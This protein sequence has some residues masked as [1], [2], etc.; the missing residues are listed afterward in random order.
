MRDDDPDSH[1]L[2]TDS[3]RS[4]GSAQATPAPVASDR[5]RGEAKRLAILAAAE[6]V[7]LSDGFAANLDRIAQTAGVSKQTIYSH[8]GSKEGLF[9]AMG[10]WMKRPMADELDPARPPEEALAAFGRVT[11]GHVVSEKA[12]RLNRLLMSQAEQFPDLAVLHCELGP[13]RTVALAARYIEGLMRDG[14]LA[15]GDPMAAAEDFVALLIGNLRH[16]LL[17]GAAERP[18][19]AEIEARAAR[20]A[21]L[22]LRTHGP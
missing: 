5:R 17:L 12:I 13:N 1:A 8:F 19:P 16:R 18:A 20:A 21:R 6:A 7:F 2:L 14:R 3:G 9:R 22:F 10:E 4:P 11:L 15:P